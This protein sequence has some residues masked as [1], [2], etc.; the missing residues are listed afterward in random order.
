[1]NIT[2]LTGRLVRDVKEIESSKGSIGALFTLA[3]GNWYGGQDPPDFIP[4]KCYGKKAEVALKHCAKGRHIGIDGRL[5][6][7]CKQLPSGIWQVY[8][9]V[10]AGRLEFLGPKS[11]HTED[12][13]DE[14][15]D[16]SFDPSA[17]DELGGP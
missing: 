2:I 3:V 6:Y 8:A 15:G 16:I 11:A 1:M 10:N 7:K 4:I 5:S 17:L 14:Q 13:G 9:A 12:S